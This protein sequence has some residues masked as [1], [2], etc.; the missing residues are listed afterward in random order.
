MTATQVYGFAA[1]F[2]VMGLGWL[3]SWWNHRD[4]MRPRCEIRQAGPTQAE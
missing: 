1:P 3:A 4:I 2:L